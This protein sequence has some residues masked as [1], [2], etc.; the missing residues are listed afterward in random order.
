MLQAI[1]IPITLGFIWRQVK[2]QR[3]ASGLDALRLLK[4]DWVSESMLEAQEECCSNFLNPGGS[5][6]ISLNEEKIASFYELLGLYVRLGT[7]DKNLC[8]NVFSYDVEHYWLIL[9]PKL[10]ALMAADATLFKEFGQLYE[11]TLTLNKRYG[12]PASRNHE[13]LTAFSNRLVA[14]RQ[15]KRER[16]KLGLASAT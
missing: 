7:L 14:S 2:L 8:W 3:Q 5:S 4:D 16:D 9:K 12:G 10:A 6:G 15:A 13:E 1:T 11:L